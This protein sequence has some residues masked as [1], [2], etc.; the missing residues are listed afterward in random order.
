M[1]G[2]PILVAGDGAT[3]WTLTRSVDF[4]APFV[5]LFGNKQA[6]GTDFHITSDRAYTWNDII[7]A[8]ARGFGVEAKIVHVPTDT[9][10]RYNKE[11]EAPLTGDKS[12]SALFDNAKVKRVAGP[13]TCSENLDE[14]LA[15]SIALTKARLKGKTPPVGKDDALMDRIADEQLALGA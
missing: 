3:P 5:N 1:S 6:L 8:V 9:L 2:K 10:V 4:A 14:V 13:F 12:N 7:N 15:E 11:W